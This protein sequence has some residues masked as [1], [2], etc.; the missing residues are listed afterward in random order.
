M[1]EDIMKCEEAIRHLAAQLDGELDPLTDGRVERHLRRCRSCF[2]RAEFERRLKASIGALQREEVSPR[3][4]QRVHA[5]IQNFT[6]AE[7][8]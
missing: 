1:N 5:L 6:P 7:T 8:G 2:S 4:E 3:L